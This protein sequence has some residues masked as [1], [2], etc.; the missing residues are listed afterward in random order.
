[1]LIIKSDTT[2]PYFNIAS[3]EYLLREL[4]DNVFMIYIN[5]PSI[6][7][8]KHQNTLAEI[9]YRYIKENNITV[10]RRLSG[11]GTV[12]HDHGNINFTFIQNVE[13]KNF[14]DFKKYT[15]PVISFLQKLGV[16]ARFEGKN[17]LRIDGLKISGNAEH[18]FKNRVLHHG[19]LLFDS[20]LNALNEAIRVQPHRYRDKAVKSIR[21]T[22]TNIKS[23]L[24]KP[25]TVA[26]FANAILSE[27]KNT[28]RSAFTFEF[29]PADKEKINKLIEEKYKTWEWNFGYSPKYELINE[30]HSNPHLYISISVEKGI[31][32]SLQIKDQQ[33]NTSM[34]NLSNA[35]IGQKHNEETIAEQI[36][37]TEIK[38]SVPTDFVY[39]FL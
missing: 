34:T 14:I 10:V 11:G 3:E 17:D 36:K 39:A 28:E 22:V 25:M 19:T 27:I 29:S 13:G 38:E 6:I 5:E 31:I 32:T 2:N 24:K 7:V 30:F 26:Q 23:H 20:Q 12:Y 8:G 21:S 35:L 37:K 33:G 16:N 18:V 15:K 9:N 4:P 1:M